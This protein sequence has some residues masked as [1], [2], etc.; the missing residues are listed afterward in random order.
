[1]K[2]KTKRNLKTLAA[3]KT[4]AR[5]A[6][7]VRGGGI[8]DMVHSAL[9]AGQKQTTKTGWDLKTNSKAG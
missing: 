7:N 6:A 4:S 3:K 2:K 5:K 8:M 1:M 9:N